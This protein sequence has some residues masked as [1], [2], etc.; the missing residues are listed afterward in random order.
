MG[1][2]RVLLDAGHYKGVNRSPVFTPYY[3]GDMTWVWQ[4]HLKQALES[5]GIEVGTTRTLITQDVD[6]YKRGAM[7]KGYDMFIS[8]HSN[9]SNDEKIDRAV[10]IHGI[11]NVDKTLANKLGLCVMKVMNLSTYQLY[12]RKYKNDEYYGVLRG[13]R[14]VGTKNRFIIEHGFHTHTATA[15]WLYNEENVKKVAYAEAQVIAEYLGVDTSVKKDDNIE[16]PKG[17]YRVITGSY[18]TKELAEK[19][20]AELTKKGYK[21][22]IAYYDVGTYK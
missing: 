1:K 10:I 3:E 16:E 21:P 13:A 9:A 22:F 2:K 14:A 11:D 7:S 8:G 5:Y 18:K 6:L 15:R 12:T 4:K 19:E 20:V 17:Y